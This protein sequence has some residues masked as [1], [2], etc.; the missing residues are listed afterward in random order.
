MF[1]YTGAFSATARGPDPCDDERR[2]RGR[3]PDRRHLLADRPRHGSTV[4]V[5]AGTTYARFSMFD[6]DVNPGTDIDLCV[7]KGTTLVG[8]SG[9][10]PRP[11]R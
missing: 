8:V 1:G 5:P 9:D 11:K 10:P 4:A 6:A 2:H 7:F 3:R